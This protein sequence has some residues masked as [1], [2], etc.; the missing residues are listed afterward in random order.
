MK[1]TSLLAL[2]VKQEAV[3]T[4]FFGQLLPTYQHWE[5]P[6][7]VSVI[8]RVRKEDI[9][10]KVKQQFCIGLDPYALAFIYLRGHYL[11]EGTTWPRFTL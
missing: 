6:Q 1:N 2:L 9:V 8:Y 4:K 3:E 5:R 7:M 11:A 10:A